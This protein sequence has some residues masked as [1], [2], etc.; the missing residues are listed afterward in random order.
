VPLLLLVAC[1]TPTE[2]SPPSLAFDG[3]LIFGFPT[4]PTVATAES[5]G[6]LVTG[7][8]RTPTLGYEIRGVLSSEGSRQLRLEVDAYLIEEP[9]PFAA[10]HYYRAHLKGLARGSYELT[11]VHT[12]LFAQIVT[13]T[14]FRGAIRVQ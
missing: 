4:L 1:R 9:L 10:Q 3:Q 7:E 2:P 8:L 14:A 12:F 11:V 5:G 6:I 13:D